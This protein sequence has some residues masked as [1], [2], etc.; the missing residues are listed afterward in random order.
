[1]K[2]LNLDPTIEWRGHNI[3]EPTTW[4]TFFNNGFKNDPTEFFPSIVLVNRGTL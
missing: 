3:L 4:V 1:M 2:Q